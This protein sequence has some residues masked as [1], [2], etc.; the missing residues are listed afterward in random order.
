MSYLTFEER[1][2]I[3]EMWE[4]YD[5]VTKI[6]KTLGRSADTIYRELA[7]GRVEGL[8]DKNFRKCLQPHSGRN[9][10][11]WKKSR[12]KDG[13]VVY[14]KKDRRKYDPIKGEIVK[15]KN[16]SRRGIAKK[17]RKENE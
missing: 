15:H 11:T 4:N 2:I 12:N 14:E 17:K 8:L 9:K 6:A 16:F 7:R 3:A 5:P 10:F 1:K 13:K